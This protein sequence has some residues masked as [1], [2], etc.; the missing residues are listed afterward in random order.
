MNSFYQEI[1]K[2][3]QNLLILPPKKLIHHFID[4]LFCVL[5][6]TTSKTLGNATIIEGKFT[7]LEIQFNE[8]VLD[9]AP[10]SDKSNQQT[11]TFFEALPNLHKKVLND[12][13]T[14]FAKDPAK[15][16]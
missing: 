3:H 4:E 2:Q 13:Q 7:E 16:R 11:E 9:F 8:L 6:S 12:A 14:I 1:A 15:K 5:F 10:Q